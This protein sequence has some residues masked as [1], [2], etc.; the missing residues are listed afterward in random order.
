[1]RR[2]AGTT[3]RID[4]RQGAENRCSSLSKP[5]VSQRIAL[6]NQRGPRLCVGVS[7]LTSVRGGQSG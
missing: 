6:A 1:M 3:R 7:N 5:E 2:R 4:I